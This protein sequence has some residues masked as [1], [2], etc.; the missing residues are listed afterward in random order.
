[1]TSIRKKLMMLAN[2]YFLLEGQNRDVIVHGATGL[3]VNVFG[4]EVD[5]YEPTDGELHI[6]GDDHGEWLAFETEGWSAEGLEIISGAVKWYAQYL[7]YSEMQI[8]EEDPRPVVKL[9]KV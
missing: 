5:R 4:L 7:D 6:F 2:N 9:R 3:R 1:L 8:S